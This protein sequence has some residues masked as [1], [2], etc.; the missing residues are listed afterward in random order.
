MRNAGRS[1]ASGFRQTGRRWC[2]VL[3]SFATLLAAWQLA[4]VFSPGGAGARPSGS[5][6][7]IL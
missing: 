2:G 4:S 3:I 7:G 5:I 6:P 1:L